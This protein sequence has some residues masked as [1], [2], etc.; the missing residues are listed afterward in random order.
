MFTIE[1]QRGKV[2]CLKS[3]NEL[4]MLWQIEFEHFRNWSLV[5]LLFCKECLILVF[6]KDIKDHENLSWGVLSQKVSLFA[7]FCVEKYM[8]D[9]SK[10]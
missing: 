8:I 10:L 3:H 2:A 6:F 7:I 9:S 5:W 1:T 4:G